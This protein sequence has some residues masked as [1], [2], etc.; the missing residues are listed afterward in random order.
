[1]W[2]NFS[3]VNSLVLPLW[4]HGSLYS[5]GSSDWRGQMDSLLPQMEGQVSDENPRGLIPSSTYEP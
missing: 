4:R 1:M 5:Y 2:M 3:N